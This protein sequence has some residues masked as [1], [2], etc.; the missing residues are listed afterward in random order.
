VT[1]SLFVRV[2]ADVFNLL[3]AKVDDIAYYYTSRLPGEPAPGRRRPL[4]SDPEARCPACPGRAARAVRLRWRQGS[5]FLT[6]GRR[7]RHQ[8]RPWASRIYREQASKRRD[9]RRNNPDI[10]DSYTDSKPPQ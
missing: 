9:K 6:S 7:D 10:P 2:T 4:P 1:A 8:L 3:D 5:C